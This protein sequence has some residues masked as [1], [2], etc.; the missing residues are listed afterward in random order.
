MS[1]V[2]K[3]CGAAEAPPEQEELSKKDAQKLEL[4]TWIKESW[5]IESWLI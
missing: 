5:L 2:K 4:K 3:D 1:E